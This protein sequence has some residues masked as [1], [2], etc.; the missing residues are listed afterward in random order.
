MQKIEVT[1]IHAFAEP[2]QLLQVEVE[3]GVG[4]GP[5][6]KTRKARKVMKVMN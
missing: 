2:E 4:V 5:E 3:V 1:A 6:Q